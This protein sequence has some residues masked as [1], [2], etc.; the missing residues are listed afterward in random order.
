MDILKKLIREYNLILAVVTTF[1]AMGIGL[2]WFV[3]D[4]TQIGLIMG[5]LAAVFVVLRF[6]VT[7]VNDP[8]LEPGTIVN[9]NTSKYPTSSVVADQ[10]PE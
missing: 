8:I 1:I 7:P 3:L 9:A 4:S 5:F 6:L 10:P 2:N